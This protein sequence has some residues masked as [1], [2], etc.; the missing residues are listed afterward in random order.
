MM[1]RNKPNIV[2][3]PK[4]LPIVTEESRYFVVT[5]GRGSSKS[6][7]IT[8]ILTMLTCEVGHTILFTRYTMVSTHISIIPEFL[9]K[10][11]IM[12]LEDMFTITKSEI[13]NLQT[14]SKI[15]FRGIKS[16][17]GDQTANLKSLQG[18]T[19]WIIEE[20][21]EL[22]SEDIFDKI[23]LSVRQKGIQNRVIL[24]MNPATKEHWIYKRF[25]QETGV[26]G[27]SNLTKGDVTYIHTTYK[28][29]EKNVSESFIT[30]M[31]RMKRDRPIKY[32]HEILGGWQDSAE[33]VVFRDWTTG[34]FNPNN[35]QVTFGMDFGFTND[36]TTL[37]GVAID[38]K[39]RIIYAKEHMYH[40]GISTTDT[41]NI[42]LKTCG[43]SLVVADSAEPRMIDEMRRQKCNIIGAKKGAGSINAG[44]AL[45]QDYDLVIDPDSLNLAKE[46]NNYA[47]SHKKSGTLI[48]SYNHLLDALRYSV[49][50]QL[51]G[52]GKISIR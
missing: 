50:H 41:A 23:D 38:K 10:I 11:E 12:G 8:A 46:L 51:M 4:Y 47:Y 14:G 2:I 5:G 3:S 32:A 39:K 40:T 43:K 28:D 37:I 45:I 18:I 7:S 19:C 15:L 9:E 21:E 48:D 22:V 1:K 35:I 49:S 27:G 31:D 6:F 25:F 30:N 33:G 44:I 36:P 29:N 20:A 34:V 17:S 52:N 26:N 24:V 42:T 13:I 16:A